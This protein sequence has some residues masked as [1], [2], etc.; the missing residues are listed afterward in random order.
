MRAEQIAARAWPGRE[1][2]IRSPRHRPRAAEHEAAHVAAGLDVGP[3]VVD[4]VKSE[5]GT[6]VEIE[7]FGDW[8]AGEVAREP[9]FDPEGERVRAKAN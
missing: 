9:L 7:I 6:P 5:V 3:D 4:F 2:E 8:I 1:L